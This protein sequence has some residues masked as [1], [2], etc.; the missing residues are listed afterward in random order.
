MLLT[1]AA[2]AAMP[3][4]ESRLACLPAARRTGLTPG[5][6]LLLPGASRAPRGA[7][8]VPAQDRLRTLSRGATGGTHR[9]RSTTLPTRGTAACPPRRDVR[10]LA[11][12]HRQ[13]SL[14]AGG[15]AGSWTPEDG[16]PSSGIHPESLAPAAGALAPNPS[17]FNAQHS[18]GASQPHLF[19]ISLSGPPLRVG[20]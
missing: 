8:S 18:S 13:L 4:L 17:H 9:P 11:R 16:S 6:V 19:S 7:S 10:W 20:V 2:A 3:A 12:G 15:A 5:R 1:M 14:A